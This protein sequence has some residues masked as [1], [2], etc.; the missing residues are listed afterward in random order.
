MDSECEATNPIENQELSARQALI[1]RYQFLDGFNS[2]RNKRPRAKRQRVELSDERCIELARMPSLGLAEWV[3]LT[4]VGLGEHNRFSIGFDGVGFTK[5]EQ[6]DIGEESLEWQEYMLRDNEHEALAFP[7]TP[8]RLLE[9]IASELCRELAGFSVP[10]AF[11]EAVAQN[12]NATGA[13]TPSIDSAEICLKEPDEGT[14]SNS[15]IFIINGREAVP[16]RAI[17][18]A[19]GWEVSPDI[20][21]A[22]L[23]HTAKGIRLENLFAY[24]P[25]TDGTFAPVLPKE[26]DGVDDRLRALS[27][28][29]QA[30][31]SDRTITRPEWLRESIPLLPAGV[32][33]W[34]DD[35]EKAFWRQF[36]PNSPVGVTYLEGTRPGDGELNF[37]PMI[38]A[39]LRQQVSEGFAL[40][41]IAQAPADSLKE[42]LSN[43]PSQ[44]RVVAEEHLRNRPT[45]K[46]V[47]VQTNVTPAVVEYVFNASLGDALHAVLCGA[48]H[49]LRMILRVLR[50]CFVYNVPQKIEHT[51]TITRI[52]LVPLCSKLGAP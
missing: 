11:Q 17:P 33:V 34:K 30:K 52:E 18:L 47:N 7:C 48:G 15:V 13:E 23:A 12:V 2:V 21:S 26:W 29:L 25:R 5:S 42:P 49:N 16:I 20:L 50:L 43:L 8:T 41:E 38:P 44:Q 6:D 31:N 4:G 51:G 9:F 39:E 32:F 3:A 10:C 27:A 40:G 36:S 28:S 46:S 37:S 45:P 22:S 14:P 35:F 1:A 19:T 24:Q